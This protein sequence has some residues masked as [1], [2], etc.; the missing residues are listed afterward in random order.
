M[1][2]E[3]KNVGAQLDRFISHGTNF[4]KP[5]KNTRTYEYEEN[6]EEPFIPLNSLSEE[7]PSENCF[8][9][10]EAIKFD[11][12]SSEDSLE[13]Q[14]KR[15]EI[16]PELAN[17]G[18]DLVNFASLHYTT[19]A[20]KITDT[21]PSYKA[22]ELTCK[23]LLKSEDYY[24]TKEANENI[25]LSESNRGNKARNNIKDAREILNNSNSYFQHESE[26]VLDEY[27]INKVV[28]HN[29]NV[30]T[31][32][33]VK[34]LN[35]KMKEN[36]KNLG[37]DIE[38]VKG[39][40]KKSIIACTKIQYA[41]RR[42][43]LKKRV[44]AL[45]EIRKKEKLFQRYMGHCATLIQQQYKRYLMRNRIKD[46][47]EAIIY[48]QKSTPC[49]LQDKGWKKEGYNDLNDRPIKELTNNEYNIEEA[50][51]LDKLK[52]QSAINRKPLEKKQFLKKKDVYD[53]KK[54][55]KKSNAIIGIKEESKAKTLTFTGTEL[56]SFQQ[57]QA[58]EEEQLES[59][60][61]ENLSENK[62]EVVKPKEYLKRRSKKVSP[63]KIQWKAARRTDCWNTRSKSSKQKAIQSRKQSQPKKQGSRA[64]NKKAVNKSM[65]NRVKVQSINTPF[66]VNELSTIYLEYHGDNQ[67]ITFT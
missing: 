30:P 19:N 59:E 46:M 3:R 41:Y 33:E 17:T 18:S 40:Q 32:I 36:L 28:K 66:T 2:G 8:S 23:K 43:L 12:E 1:I 62:E 51:A 49:N 25:K 13:E 44:H 7:I 60:V 39:S 52:P 4:T 11:E 38:R 58:D 5:S 48:L 50:I 22:H 64:M 29:R 53:P 54:A 21:E 34:E 57:V 14:S 67:C 47:C 31:K 55:I 16:K 61:K 20:E 9:P 10:V 35:N 42:Y 24:I 56:K 45:S 65:T 37:M 15:Q 26:A 27:S 6:Q 63:K